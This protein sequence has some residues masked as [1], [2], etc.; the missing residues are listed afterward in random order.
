M[1]VK[2]DNPRLVRATLALLLLASS[3]AAAPIATLLDEGVGGRAMAMGG[4]GAAL[5]NDATAI[6]WNPARLAGLKRREA[7]AAHAELA[8]SRVDFAGYT[9]PEEDGGGAG[10]GLTYRNAPGR[11]AGDLETSDTVFTFAYSKN[12]I[13]DGAAG[14]ALKYVRS[15]VPGKD[16]HTF[17]TD[18]ALSRK[19]EG[20]STALVLRNA[21]PRLNYGGLHKD[22]PL[23]IA[24]GF[25]YEKKPVAAGLDYEYR[26][27][28]GAHDVG[29]GA[30]YELFNGLFARGGWTT[31]DERAPA[32]VV[33][34]GFTIGGGLELGGLRLDY[35]FRPKAGRYH[36][37]DVAFRF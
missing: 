23:T 35:A 16:A 6:Y 26:P 37:A 2:W 28:T 5:A 12:E 15:R 17:A 29:V 27:R 10:L 1:L 36:R 32:L 7:A 8:D 34:R 11:P 18:F 24:L 4:V 30:E 20:R 21:G 33:S 3:A 14:L 25:G 9:Q 31:K 19:E 13:E 22:L